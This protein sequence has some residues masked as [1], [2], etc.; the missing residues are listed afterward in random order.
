MPEKEFRVD[1]PGSVFHGRTGR[2]VGEFSSDLRR[3]SCG[4]AA[5]DIGEAEPVFFFGYELVDV[6][7][8]ED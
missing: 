8:E 3:V 1:N 5:V 4:G 7:E 2:P 6:S